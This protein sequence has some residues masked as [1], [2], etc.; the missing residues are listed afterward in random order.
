MR[1]SNAETPNRRKQILVAA[2][3]VV[4]LGVLGWPASS[5]PLAEDEATAGDRPAPPARP[6]APVQRVAVDLPRMSLPEIIGAD[7]F[8]SHT[9]SVAKASERPSAKPEGDGET[10]PPR[11]QAVYGGVRGSTALV[12]HRILREGDELSAGRRVERIAPHGIT[13]RHTSGG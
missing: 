8:V 7:P 1:K 9:A 10:P 6:A 11:L 3:A 12:E 2:L 13:I 5:E 4:L